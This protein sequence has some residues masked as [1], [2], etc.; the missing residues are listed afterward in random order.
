MTYPSLRLLRSCLQHLRG[1]ARGHLQ[2]GVTGKHF[3]IDQY[4]MIGWEIWEAQQGE[5]NLS[6]LIFRC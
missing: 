4:S 1:Q 3:N 2:R 6:M 5:N